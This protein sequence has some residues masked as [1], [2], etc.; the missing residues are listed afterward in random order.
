[1]S[2]IDGIGDEVTQFL[3]AVFLVIIVVVAW[4][5]TNT[6]RDPRSIRSV[7]LV[8]YRVRMLRDYQRTYQPNRPTSGQFNRQYNRHPT[9]RAINNSRSTSTDNIQ[10]EDPIDSSSTVAPET[11]DISSS[12]NNRETLPQAEIT[13]TQTDNAFAEELERESIIRVMDADETEVRR[14]RIAFFAA[15]RE[16]AAAGTSS[17]H[18][19]TAQPQPEQE[20]EE[21]EASDVN[22][23]EGDYDR[24]LDSTIMEH[25]Y[26]ELPIIDNRTITIKLKY[27]NDEMKVVTAK[28]QEKLGDF[29]L[30]HFAEEYSNDRSVR[31]IFNGKIL[32][33][34]NRTI[35]SCGIFH[36]CVVH[37][38]VVQGR[39]EERPRGTPA[40]EP[41]SGSRAAVFAEAAQHAQFTRLQQ[42]NAA[43]RNGRQR[44]RREWNLGTL[45]SRCTNF[46]LICAWY[47]RYSVPHIW[48]MTATLCLVALTGFSFVAHVGVFMPNA[49]QAPQN[50]NIRAAQ[51]GNR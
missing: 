21:E 32:S 37:C 49:Q 5:S 31:L 43:D 16:V 7:Y 50:V 41:S 36:N 12:V 42:Q 35:S 48:T 10:L 38:L 18:P 11:P 17:V 24:E 46:L 25:N 22:I 2:V 30:R 26:A 4:W 29:K 39:R 45:L 27:T 14:R 47:L 28:L 8:D 44:Q 34:D 6:S 33:D 40:G 9:T 13:V 3:L 23:Y 15:P 19:E 1:M 51:I 20:P